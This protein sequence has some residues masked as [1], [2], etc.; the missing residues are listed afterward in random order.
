MI[1]LFFNDSLVPECDFDQD[2][3][4]NFFFAFLLF[5]DC[6]RLIMTMCIGRS[7]RGTACSYSQRLTKNDNDSLPQ[8][9]LVLLRRVLASL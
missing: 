2:M 1:I 8:I 9:K 5:L 3:E 6:I 7:S 4:P